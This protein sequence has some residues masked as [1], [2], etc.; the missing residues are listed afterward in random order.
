M[1]LALPPSLEYQYLCQ[2]KIGWSKKSSQ[3]LR[4]LWTS[5]GSIPLQVF[6]FIWLYCQVSS[7]FQ[8]DKPGPWDSFTS[9]LMLLIFKCPLM[10]LHWKC[11]NEIL[12]V[13][14]DNSDN[15]T[16]A[17]VTLYRVRWKYSDLYVAY[18][19]TPAVL[20]FAFSP[21]VNRILQNFDDWHSL[22]KMFCRILWMRPLFILALKKNPHK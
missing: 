19:K 14:S 12:H 4:S 17:W 7:W 18:F 5:P 22:I 9:A 15:R 20:C 1:F 11:I 6:L 16:E 2:H 21:L 8:N 10:C 3:L 13:L